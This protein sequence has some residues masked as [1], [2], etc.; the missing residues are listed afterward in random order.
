MYVDQ[1]CSNVM[2]RH[3]NVSVSIILQRTFN[4][5]KFQVTDGPIVKIFLLFIVIVE[6]MLALNV[7]HSSTT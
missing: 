7:Y 3:L 5:S 4:P 6:R 2:Y 1:I